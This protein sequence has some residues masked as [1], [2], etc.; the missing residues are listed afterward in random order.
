[1]GGTGTLA[2]AKDPDGQ[3]INS[4]S[5]EQYAVGKS[6]VHVDDDAAYQICEQLRGSVTVNYGHVQAWTANMPL[7]IDEDRDGYAY[8]TTGGKRAEIWR[9]GHGETDE[10]DKVIARFE[11]IKVTVTGLAN[12]ERRISGQ[13]QKVVKEL[14][15]YGIVDPQFRPGRV[16]P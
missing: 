7:D 10:L 13:L 15:K 14:E 9:P 3:N 4:K 1:M 6:D 8:D 12:Q 11:T 2:N 16:G 5:D